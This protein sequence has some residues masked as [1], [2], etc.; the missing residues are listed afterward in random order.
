MIQQLGWVLLSWLEKSQFGKCW[1]G[2]RRT[3]EGSNSTHSSCQMKDLGALI[4][5]CSVPIY[6]QGLSKGMD[7]AAGW[8]WA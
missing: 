1:D 6:P 5:R 8:S 3:Q 7:L 2:E 4:P